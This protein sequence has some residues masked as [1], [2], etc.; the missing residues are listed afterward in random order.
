MLRQE[1]SEQYQKAL[2][3][4]QKQHR[5]DVVHGRYP[6]PQVLDEFFDEYMSAGRVE[7]GRV[8]IPMD[9][10]VGTVTS[11]RKSTFSSNFMPLLPLESEFAMKWI[12]LCAAHLGDEG[13]RE[14]IVCVEYMGRFYVQEGN[15]RVSVLKSYE[16]STIPGCLRH[17][18]SGRGSGRQRVDPL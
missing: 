6:Y 13:I 2:K 3:L 14:P 7:I 18:S 1:A 15:K 4:G 8:E 11:G 12:N 17:R 9:Q 16:A 5:N 10:I